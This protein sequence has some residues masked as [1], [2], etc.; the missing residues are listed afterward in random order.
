MT[1]A[2]AFI[3]QVAEKGEIGHAYL[4]ESPLA[5]QAERE[6][7]KAARIVA[8][9]KKTGC[10]VCAS[11]RAL[12]S[13]NH[14]DVISLR[15]EKEAYSVQEIRKQLV[16]DMG[17]KPYRFEKKIYLIPQAESLSS[18]C[19]NVM[20]KT[21]EEPPSYGVI[22]LA[23]RNKNAFLPTLLSRLVCLSADE[24]TEIDGGIHESNRQGYQAFYELLQDIQKAYAFDLL[25]M[26]E[27]LKKQGLEA[28]E[29]LELWEKA[30]NGIF[31]AKGE[32]KMSGDD[33][34]SALYGAYA[35]RL[36]D[37]ALKDLWER[38]FLARNQ[39]RFN[40]RAEN[41]IGQLAIAFRDALS[42]SEEI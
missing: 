28:E 33:P 42:E 31:Q 32:G 20:L 21:L 41:A 19:Q 7:K 13:G 29:Q 10:G 8:C 12:D 17:I 18:L 9:E 1:Q 15:K 35:R 14:P 25:G 26:Y 36:S 37:E 24:N 27:T 30:L 40:I 23:A 11:C 22:M 4:L 5:G 39:L 6:M 16:G 38:L 2:E 34:C 3:R